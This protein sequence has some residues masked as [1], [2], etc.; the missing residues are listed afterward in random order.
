M[1][2]TGS[3]GIGGF[4]KSILYTLNEKD[5]DKILEFLQFQQ[6]LLLLHLYV[7]ILYTLNEKDWDRIDIASSTPIL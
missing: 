6:E 5:W 4:F 7:S 3:F 2:P 1:Y